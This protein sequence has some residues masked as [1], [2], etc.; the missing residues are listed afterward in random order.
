MLAP[1]ELYERA[2]DIPN[3]IFP[4]A[5]LFDGQKV[6]VYYGVADTVIGIAF[7]YQQEI[8]DFIKANLI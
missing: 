5:A 4:C 2:G 8:I 3:V 6:A 7:G 1:A